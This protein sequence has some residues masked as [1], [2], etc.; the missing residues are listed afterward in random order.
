M[1]Y[2]YEVTLNNGDKLEYGTFDKDDEALLKQHIEI[3]HQKK[4]VSTKFIGTRDEN[5]FYDEE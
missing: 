3:R 5:D 1:L 2:M 4:V